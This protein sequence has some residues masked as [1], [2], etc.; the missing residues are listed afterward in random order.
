MTVRRLGQVGQLG[1]FDDDHPRVAKQFRPGVSLG[2]P[3]PPPGGYFSGRLLADLPR[4]RDHRRR[5][6]DQSAEEGRTTADEG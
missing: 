3:I 5:C 4:G 2:A 1:E 6:A